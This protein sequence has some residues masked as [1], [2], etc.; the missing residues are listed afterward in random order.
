MGTCSLSYSEQMGSS[1]LCSCSVS[2]ALCFRDRIG[3][4]SSM[5]TGNAKVPNVVWALQCV[6]IACTIA[7]SLFLLLAH[8]TT[9]VSHGGF[10]DGHFSSWQTTKTQSFYQVDGP[11]IVVLALVPPILC[12]L[13]LVGAALFLGR[14]IVVV[15]DI[16]LGSVLIATGIVSFIVAGLLLFFVAGGC[17]VAAGCIL[18]DRRMNGA[19]HLFD[20][21]GLKGVSGG[22]R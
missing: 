1:L 22:S 3:A 8:Q 10:V 19:G 18:A 5:K 11:S 7:F 9:S 16:A 2:S 4:A 6:A 12:G 14:R 15:C 20:A 17:L 13:S 21:R